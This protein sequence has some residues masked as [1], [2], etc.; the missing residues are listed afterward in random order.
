MK[1]LLTKIL[2]LFTP[3]FLIWLLLSGLAHSAILTASGF[4]GDA[5]LSLNVTNPVISGMVQ[6]WASVQIQVLGIDEPFTLGDQV[7]LN[8]FEDDGPIG[9]DLIFTTMFS[10]TTME[11]N[12]Q[13]V[14]R[15]FPVSFDPGLFIG[16]E[17]S[18]LEF[19]ANAFVDKQACG[20]LCA[21]DQPQTSSLSINVTTPVPT[22]SAMLLMGT[23]I[24]GLVI[25]RR[26]Q[27]RK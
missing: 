25:F 6:D 24:L 13:S 15:T 17:G 2:N 23:G 22:P 10:V 1:Y 4:D 8:V 3:I 16:G 21:N 18:S 11:V 14:D 9:D 7:T 19:F 20:F 26:Y 12:D 5:T 27:D